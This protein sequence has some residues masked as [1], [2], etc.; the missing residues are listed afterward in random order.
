MCFIEASDSLVSSAPIGSKS[1]EHADSSTVNSPSMSPASEVNCVSP[2]GTGTDD[3]LKPPT[4]LHMSRYTDEHINNHIEARDGVANSY[5]QNKHQSTVPL[6][7][8]SVA[9]SNGFTEGMFTEACSSGSIFPT[10][11]MPPNNNVTQ[12]S[13]EALFNKIKMPRTSTTGIENTESFLR[14]LFQQTPQPQPQQQHGSNISSP[15]FQNQ[16]LSQ[17]FTNNRQFSGM[18]PPEKMPSAP[19]V[20]KLL[21]DKLIAAFA[22][23]AISGSHSQSGGVPTSAQQ[24]SSMS[25]ANEHILRQPPAKRSRM[26]YGKAKKTAKEK[27]LDLSIPPPVNPTSNSTQ[28]I[29]RDTVIFF[30]K[31]ICTVY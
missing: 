15:L 21:Q 22:N 8:V 5:Q 16:W 3:D 13:V 9:T 31:N 2:S 1:E 30:R 14:T 27:P 24:H 17:L 23:A 6:P 4:M 29:I 18:F 19:N 7:N 10:S 12:Q 25:S 20:N 11:L 26:G 28:L